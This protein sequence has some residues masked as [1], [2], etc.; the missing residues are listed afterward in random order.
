MTY[1]LFAGVDDDYNFPPEVRAALAASTE[2]RNTVV[3]MTTT[4]RNNLSGAGLWDGRT[5]LNTTTDR[6]N[7][8][9]LGTTSWVA[10]ADLTDART[11]VYA[12]AAARL[13]VASPYF[14]QHAIETD[15]R[16][17]YVFDGDEWQRLDT[18]GDW[19]TWVPTYNNSFILL[20]ARYRKNGIMVEGEWVG[21]F[22]GWS[23]GQFV[24]LPV[25]AESGPTRAVGMSTWD[26]G[27]VIGLGWTVVKSG[28]NTTMFPMGHGADGS[29]AQTLQWSNTT[30]GGIDTDTTLHMGFRYIANA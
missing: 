5:I 8:Y 15:T 3:P 4:Q 13:A 16:R 11:T 1:E 29:A 30:P 12:N 20:E 21:Q 23:A 10:I 22:Q 9:D 2:M 28:Q 19:E 17:E 18:W 26:N 14:G 6:I 24:S 27:G 25:A 7:R